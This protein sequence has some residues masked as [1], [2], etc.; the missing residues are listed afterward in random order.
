MH[1]A[2]LGVA[3]EIALQAAPDAPPSI[4]PVVVHTAQYP[5]SY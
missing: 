4:L 1:P 5:S 2:V 3:P